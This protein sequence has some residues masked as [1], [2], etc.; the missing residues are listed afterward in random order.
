MQ[1][2]V[3]FCVYPPV[4][5][6]NSWKYHW[7]HY[8]TLAVHYVNLF[9]GFAGV[10]VINSLLWGG[11]YNRVSSPSFSVSCCLLLQIEAASV[12]TQ[13]TVM[14]CLSD[15]P[16]LFSVLITTSKPIALIFLLISLISLFITHF[17]LSLFPGVDTISLS[18]SLSPCSC[19]SYLSIL[20][21]LRSESCWSRSFRPLGCQSWHLS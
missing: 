13:G 21:F 2:P 10:H 16:V 18:L 6:G 7:L 5:L 17:L 15:V 14:L 1:I 20:L 11:H 8:V 9:D 12:F 19:F 4:T 3:L